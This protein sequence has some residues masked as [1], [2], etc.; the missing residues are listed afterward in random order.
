[1][2]RRRIQTVALWALTSLCSSPGLA[3]PLDPSGQ[4]GEVAA[5]MAGAASPAVTE[6]AGTQEEEVLDFAA[7]EAAADQKTAQIL[8]AV[9]GAA[10]ALS[11]RTGFKLYADLLVDY[12]VGQESFEFRPNHIVVILQ[13]QILDNLLFATH[14]SDD[15]VFFEL[16]W[17]ITPRLT[18]KAGKLF[19][20]FGTNEFHHIVGGRVDELSQF[21]PETWSDYGVGLSYQLLDT[22][23]F[24]ADYDLYLVNGFQGEDR[25]LIGAA[26][27][28]DNNMAKGY[29]ARLKLTVLNRVLVTG[30]LYHDVW[31]RDQRN[32]LLFYSVG[33]ELRPGLIPLPVVDRL[34][35]RGE[36]ARGEFK[37][38]QRNYQQG[39][40]RHAYARAG[41]YGEA[42]LPLWE[43]VGVRLRGGRINPD[44]TVTDDGDLWVL[45]PAVIL[46]KGKVTVLLAYQALL[47][48]GRAYSPTEPADIVYGKFFIQF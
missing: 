16:N 34:R 28:S 9:A 22:D 29:G 17:M 2:Q 27:T 6:G 5:D 32:N 4:V 48:D 37:L 18:L 24:S 36:W 8:Q 3:G 21:L 11:Q 31:S 30:S 43:W 20:P 38:P 35:L 47:Q 15:P 10:G 19:I 46:G 33:L 26:T 13:M 12:G 1:M 44:N 23:W 14:I 40:L 42:L 25:P 45:E 7:E 41:F 39:V